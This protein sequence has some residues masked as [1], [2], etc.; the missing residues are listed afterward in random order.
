MSHG[1][2]YDKDFNQLTVFERLNRSLLQLFLFFS[3]H[4]FSELQNSRAEMTLGTT[5]DNFK[6]NY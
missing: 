4:A 6:N 5:R 3:R 1:K 2:R